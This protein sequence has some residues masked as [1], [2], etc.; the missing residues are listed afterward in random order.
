MNRNKWILALVTLL[1]IGSAAIV[2][3]K[4]KSIQRLGAPGVKTEPIAGTKNVN[5]ILPAQVL[6]YTSELLEQSEIVTNVLPKDTSYGQRRYTAP[7]K[8]SV[9]VN[10]VLM[11]SDRTS[12]HK[13]DFCLEGAGWRIDQAATVQTTIPIEKPHHYELPVTKLLVTRE[14]EDKGQKVTLS[15]VYVYWYVADGVLSGDPSGFGRMWSMSK[16][17]VTTG[18]LQRWAYIT[19]FAVCPPGLEDETYARLKQLI[20]ASVPEFQLT[21]K[22]KTELAGSPP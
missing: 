14:F 22:P 6:D 17:L 12:L 20:T 2:L 10:V 19:Y 18:I 5:V 4:Y 8:L 16:T 7:D 15:G 1:L 9:Q 21:P 11:G 3:A 13:P